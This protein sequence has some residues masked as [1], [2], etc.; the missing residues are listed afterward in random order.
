[1]KLPRAPHAWRLT[2]RQ[3]VAVQRRLAARVRRTPSRGPLRFIAGLDAAFSIDGTQCIAGVV[4]WDRETRAVV[5]RQ[6]A[7]RRLAFPYVPGLLGFREAPALLAAL[8]R[9][10]HR[11]DALMCDGQG[12]AHPRRFGIAC[13]LGVICGLPAI[14]CAKSRLTGTHPEPGFSRGS[15]APLTDRGEIIGEVLRTQTGLRPVYLSIGH[16]MDLPT[17]R[18]IVLDCA[19]RYR[20][21]EPARLA[22]QLV[23]AAKR[24]PRAVG[25]A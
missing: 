16:R 25:G 8:R 22:D 15:A 14:G 19:I 17:A 24:D 20:L 4:L 2:P 11:A 6:T 12:L 5:E 23:A 9:L 13:H 10:R 1:M 21:P 3:A 18:R 7:V